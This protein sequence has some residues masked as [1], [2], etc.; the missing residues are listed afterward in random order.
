MDAEGQ[1]VKR[2]FR[3]PGEYTITL[4]ISDAFG[5]KQPFQTTIKVTVNP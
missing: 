2:K 3:V 4:T 5:L 1:I